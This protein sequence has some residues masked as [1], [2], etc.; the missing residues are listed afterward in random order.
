VVLAPLALGRRL[1][2]RHSGWI[3]ARGPR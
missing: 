1:S 2:R 3:P